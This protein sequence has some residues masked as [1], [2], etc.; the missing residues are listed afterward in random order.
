[1][2]R[3]ISA[4][5]SAFGV[6]RYRFPD[7]PTLFSLERKGASRHRRAPVAG[8]IGAT[9]LNHFTICLDYRRDRVILEPNR[10]YSEPVRVDRSGMQLVLS[11]GEVL[12]AGVARKSP[13]RRAG[14]K[15]L[16]RLVMLDGRP[17]SELGL[18]HIRDVLR[19]P[20][21]NRVR[22]LLE[23]REKERTVTLKLKDY[24]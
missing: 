14:V 11:D 16:D 5:L 22:L 17:A 8:K 7:L 21:G 2:V 20:A 13:A 6:G 24:R 1:M 4:H 12:V 3:Q 18:P 15:V 9:L 23:R 19:G 10:F